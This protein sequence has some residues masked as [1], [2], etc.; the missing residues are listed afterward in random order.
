MGEDVYEGLVGRA[1]TL[2][3]CNM[4]KRRNGG[5]GASGSAIQFVSSLR[6]S[7]VTP[8]LRL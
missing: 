7:S 3:K 8:F 6:S 5:N 1:E 2:M 4:E